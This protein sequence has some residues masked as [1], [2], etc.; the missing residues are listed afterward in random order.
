MGRPALSS[1]C[2]RPAILP[3]RMRSTSP[4]R[5]SF[6]FEVRRFRREW[7]GLTQ[8]QGGVGP[9]ALAL[10]PSVTPRT[11][12]ARCSGELG[13][14]PPKRLGNALKR[15]R[16]ASGPSAVLLAISPG[17]RAGDGTAAVLH[18]STQMRV[19]L[20]PRTGCWTGKCSPRSARRRCLSRGG[21]GA[22][23]GSGRTHRWATDCLPLETAPLAMLLIS[24]GA[25]AATIPN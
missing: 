3:D 12:C 25:G 15:V 22:T 7:R 8:L 19:N 21:G 24:S 11:R 2:N 13:Q 18:Q 23:T 20:L 4:W 16:F 5:Q 17:Q 14:S 6:G 9:R 10:P 1:W